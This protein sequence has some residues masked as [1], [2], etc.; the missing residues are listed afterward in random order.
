MPKR[1]SFLLR[2]DPQVYDDLRV[3]ADD[4]LRSLNAQIEFLLRDALKKR[5]RS[6]KKA[7]KKSRHEDEG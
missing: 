1:K 4:D 6:R 5:G 2:L 7:A 3:W